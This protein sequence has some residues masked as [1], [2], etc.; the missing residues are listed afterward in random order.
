V[1]PW[2]IGALVLI[3]LIS[4]VYNQEARG[5]HAADWS[6]NADSAILNETM[7]KLAGGNT[8][9][10]TG[11]LNINVDAGDEISFHY[12][13][14]DGAVCAAGA[15]R[16]FVIVNGINSNSWDGNP[17]QCGT[18]GTV[19]FQVSN[20][21]LITQAG[22]VFDQVGSYVDGSSVVVSDLTVDGELVHF[23]NPPPPDP[24]PDPDPEP[25]PDPEPD[26]EPSPKQ[27]PKV[28]IPTTVPAGE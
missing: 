13:L 14:R 20:S 15:P 18:D 3:G 1:W 23:L 19:T 25:E 7:V 12:D 28:V 5:D 6:A 27:T 8:S 24:V 9:V 21:G 11:N 10:E 4:A 26:P 2:V 17:G 16:V 22:V